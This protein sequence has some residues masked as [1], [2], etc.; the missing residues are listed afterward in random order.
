MKK[1]QPLP[2]VIVT[3]TTKE[4]THDRPISAA[5]IVAEGWMNATDWEYTSQKAL[6]LFAFGQ[7]EAAQRGL[8]LVD[9]KYEFGKDGAGVIHVIDEI[10]TP[11]SSRYWI[12][13]SYAARLAEGREPENIDKEFLRIWFRDNCDPYR[14][15]NL[16]DAPPSLVAELSRRYIMLYERITGNTFVVPAAGAVEAP[17]GAAI[18]R[19]LAPFFAPAH[20]RI[21]VLYQREH[22]AAEA[23]TRAVVAA[24]IARNAGHYQDG[25]VASSVVASPGSGAVLHPEHT[26]LAVEHYG[27]DVATGTLP[28]LQLCR[29]L[30]A[31]NSVQLRTVVVVVAV[32]R[33]DDIARLV[34]TQSRLPCIALL[35]E[36]GGGGGHGGLSLEVQ[37]NV[38]ALAGSAVLGGVGVQSVVSAAARIMGIV[39]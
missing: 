29:D 20:R 12:A 9:T 1:N 13:E 11:D 33:I 34:A 7:K 24:A 30:A 19:S 36:S 23:A 8:I 15:V 32:G 27:V 31:E 17:T 16:P 37:A 3:P 5:E 6:E 39:E 21:A 25:V 35:S 28:L 26:R 22:E 38:C 18:S 4:D 10:H 2:S 14:D